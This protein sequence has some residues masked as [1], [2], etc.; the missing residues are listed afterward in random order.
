M[1]D[2][3]K[4]FELGIFYDNKMR[5]HYSLK[6]LLPVFSDDISYSNLEI[7]N[8]MNAVFAYRT[9]DQATMQ[10]KQFI[11]GEIR[12]YCA[13]DTYAEYIVYHGLLK[14]IKEETCQT[15]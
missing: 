1:M 13:M 14:T 10:Q 2:L 6:N 9:Y 4:P 15:L 3:S 12:R 7:Q 11:S 8:G 5:G